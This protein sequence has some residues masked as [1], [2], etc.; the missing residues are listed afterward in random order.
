M[1][2]RGSLTHT[3]I[4][5]SRACLCVPQALTTSPA[6]RE[7]LAPSESVRAVF[8]LLDADPKLEG[9]GLS[10]A[11]ARSFPEPPV[12]A[13]ALAATEAARMAGILGEK[14]TNGDLS[15]KITNG[16]LSEKSLMGT[17]QKITN[18]DLSENSL[19]GTFQTMFQCRPKI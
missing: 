12:E 3:L 4:S 9:K 15:E 1:W 5:V 11:F 7:P 2:F 17:F 8:E 14:I 6:P 18:G 13:G 16:D 10:E 19:M